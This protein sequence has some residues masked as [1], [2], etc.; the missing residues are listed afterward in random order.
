MAALVSSG[1]SYLCNLQLL[2]ALATSW[3]AYTLHYNEALKQ[4]QART[5]GKWRL[6]FKISA[7][8]SPDIAAVPA[9]KHCSAYTRKLFKLQTTLGGLY[10]NPE[11]Q[12]Y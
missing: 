1:M 7:H 6:S 5:F 3:E 4:Q 10:K 11:I 12:K 9:P 8:P 2:L